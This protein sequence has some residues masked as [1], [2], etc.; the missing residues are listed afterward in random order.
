[1]GPIKEEMLCKDRKYKKQPAPSEVE[2]F[3]DDDN[4][5]PR[6][7]KNISTKKNMIKMILFLGA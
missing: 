2:T 3:V 5:A 7:F 4:D 6:T 1:L